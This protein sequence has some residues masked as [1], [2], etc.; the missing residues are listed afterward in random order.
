[1]IVKREK[2]LKALKA[3][4]PGLAKK[5][6]IE[7]ST[8]FVFLNGQ[9]AT[10][11]DEITVRHTA[12]IG[13]DGAVKSDEFMKLIS[14]LKA[15]EISINVEESQLQIQAGK[16]KA[17]L[18]MDA[19]IHLPLE[20]V[21]DPE[22][23]L[24]F[25]SGLLEALNSCSFSVSRDLANP[26]LTCLF[27]EQNRVIS[28][29]K[30][31]IT[32]YTMKKGK[33]K[34]FLLPATAVPHLNKMSPTHYAV[35]KNWAHFKNADST[36]YSIRLFE[37]TFP[38]VEK[39]LNVKGEKIK[40]PDD[41]KEVLGKAEIFTESAVTSDSLVSIRITKGRIRVKGENEIGWLEES[42]KLKYK[43]KE[44]E[45]QIN[46]AFLSQFMDKGQSI[47]IGESMIK[48]EDESLEHVA[49]IIA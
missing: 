37:G 40:F 38:E 45:F 20:S 16:T 10:Y 5:E 17:G 9:V 34:P 39:F 8:S 28:S 2:L 48:F 31:R 25:P 7:Q 27:V 33:I 19:E 35:T 36:V 24:K 47:I 26:I 43:G 49:G 18:V 22:K 6:V 30:W 21:T 29:D 12:D 41:L 11:N 4:A 23:W 46:P 13:V 42:A 32:R 44:M 1:M 3:V 15:E 14:K